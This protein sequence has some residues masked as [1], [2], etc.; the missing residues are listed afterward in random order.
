MRRA[1]Y[2]SRLALVMSSAN[3][4]FPLHNRQSKHV[5]KVTATPFQIA[6]CH[7]NFFNDYPPYQSAI[8]DSI[9]CAAKILNNRFKVKIGCENS[10]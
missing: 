2:G 6:T 10:V 5:F 9:L 1:G 4:I 3:S 7:L 8:G